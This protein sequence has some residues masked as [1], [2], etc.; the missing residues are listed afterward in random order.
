MSLLPIADLVSSWA[1]KY[2]FGYPSTAVLLLFMVVGLSMVIV[3]RRNGRERF[4]IWWENMFYG[5][6]LW[7]GAMS[8]VMGG[9]DIGKKTKTCSRKYHNTVNR[10]LHVIVPY[11][12]T[13]TLL[14]WISKRKASP[15]SLQL[16]QRNGLQR[17]SRH[18]VQGMNK[19]QFHGCKNSV[20]LT[21]VSHLKFLPYVWLC[22]FCREVSEK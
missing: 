13:G 1:P 5:G 19:V 15:T 22:S 3:F 21:R 9:G 7:V 18:V 10:H 14:S 4:R 16:L 8:W 6:D 11:W 20:F 17:S 12:R 2:W